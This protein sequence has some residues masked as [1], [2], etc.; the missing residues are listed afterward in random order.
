MVQIYS[1]FSGYIFIIK[2]KQ[3]GSQEV[4]NLLKEIVGPTLTLTSD[5]GS[6]L[7]KNRSIKT[8]L[9]LWGVP[10]LSLSLPYS[11]LHNA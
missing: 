7:L 2:C 11:P 3:E 10:T 5:N 9:A 8:F 1:R 4:I 6:T